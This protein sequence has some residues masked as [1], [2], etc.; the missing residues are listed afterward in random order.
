[1]RTF[2]TNMQDQREKLGNNSQIF[3]PKEFSA[4]EAEIRKMNT[5]ELGAIHFKFKH[6]KI[7]EISDPELEMV[8]IIKH[9]FRIAAL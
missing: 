8:L 1:M 4:I 2:K 9:H 5:P 3:T 6:L 7:N